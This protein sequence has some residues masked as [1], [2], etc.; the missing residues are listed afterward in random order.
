MVTLEEARGRRRKSRDL[1]AAAT[2]SLA[3]AQQARQIEGIR[4]SQQHIHDVADADPGFF[5]PHYHLANTY[6]QMRQS[7]P[8]AL[9]RAVAHYYAVVLRDPRVGGQAPACHVY[10]R[11]AIHA[12]TQG[13]GE[14]AARYYNRFMALFPLANEGAAMSAHIR[15]LV[16]CGGPW[17]EHFLHGAT[18][19]QE[20]DH[21]TALRSLQEASRL[22]PAF[23]AVYLLMGCSHR[24][25][26]HNDL[27][28][29]AFDRA[30]TLDPDP[31]VYLETGL[32]YQKMGNAFAE[33]RCYARA[34]ELNPADA[35]AAYR[36]GA[37]LVEANKVLPKA[38]EYLQHAVMLSP[39][40]PWASRAGDMIW[41][42]VKAGAV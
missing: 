20:G 33:E 8:G 10:T 13:M 21:K 16:E 35:E 39:E 40:A 2:R 37:R 15:W 31:R 24:E 22:Y 28:I 34:L 12:Q 26:G 23:A 29:V 14:E 11:L 1:L 19:A 17:Y 27:A 25:L 38:S 9:Q 4:L 32:T 41:E 3:A 6:Y 42:L 36:L 30:L 7:D 5:E 18:V